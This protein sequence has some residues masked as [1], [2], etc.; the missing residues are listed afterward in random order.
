[1]LDDIHL[2]RLEVHHPKNCCYYSAD[3]NH[4]PIGQKAEVKQICSWEMRDFLTNYFLIRDVKSKFKTHNLIFLFFL[5]KYQKTNKE[6][7]FVF[8]STHAFVKINLMKT[9]NKAQIC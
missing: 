2:R 8:H 9:L 7:K 5:P 1:M 3:T 6:R 4:S